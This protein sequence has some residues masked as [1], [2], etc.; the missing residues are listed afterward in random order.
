MNVARRPL[1]SSGVEVPV[2][3]LGTMTFGTPLDQSQATEVVERALSFGIDFFDTADI[4]EGYTRTLGSP[5]GTAESYLGSA[6]GDRREQV[7]ITS[8]VGNPIGDDTYRGSGLGRAHILHQIEASLRR[9]GTDYLDFYE[10]HVADPDTELAESVAAMAELVD[11]SSI[12]HWGFS[13]FSGEEVAQMISL[14]EEHGWPLPAIA[15]PGYSWLQR[16]LE[17]DYLSLCRERGI[18][19]TPYRALE[20]GVLSGKYRRGQEPGTDTRLHEQP[21]WLP[22][23]ADFDR[24]EEF[25]AEAHRTGRSPLQHALGW[26]LERPGVASLVVGVRSIDQIDKLVAAVGA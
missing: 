11:R 18:G 13:N 24:I 3:C 23:G 1:G 4:Y 16:E 7:L 10:L 12:R 17:A 22:V 19:V 25:E 5:G 6:L 15:Q 2:L 26:L 8:K 14:C 21:G 9:L 20:G